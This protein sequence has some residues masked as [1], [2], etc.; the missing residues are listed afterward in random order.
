MARVE[1]S[2]LPERSVV[3]GILGT[4]DATSWGSPDDV[5]ELGGRWAMLA[6]CRSDGQCHAAILVLGGREARPVPAQTA[7]DSVRTLLGSHLARIER[8]H[9][10]AQ[11]A[12]PPPAADEP[13]DPPSDD[14]IF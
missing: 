7:L 9:L 2:L 10:R 11:P 4:D 12:W 3:G 6:P 13:E 8:V 1:R 14:L 5:H